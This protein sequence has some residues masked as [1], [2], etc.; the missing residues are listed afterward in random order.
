MRKILKLAKSSIL[1]IK[2]EVFYKHISHESEKLLLEIIPH[3]P[4]VGGKDNMFTI[5]LE[6]NACIIA[7]YKVLKVNGENLNN[8]IGIF[9][10]TTEKFF[11]KFP[12]FIRKLMG[13]YMLSKRFIRKLIKLSNET[14]Q[15]KYPDNWLF[16][17]K[18]GNNKEYRW[19]ANYSQCAV[20]N[21]WKAQG[22]EEILPYCCFFD[23]IN[24]KYCKTGIQ[25]E[26]T[27]GEGSS[28]CIASVKKGR[29]MVVPEILKKYIEVD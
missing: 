22:L 2:D 7:L 4:Y 14:H 11:Q 26:S 21:F 13:R 24:S 28:S 27:I 23:V 5:I 9:C 16:T 20:C 10:E 19:K 1:K 15:R 12:K 29:K 17:V 6:V 8:I 25:F 18:K 3:I